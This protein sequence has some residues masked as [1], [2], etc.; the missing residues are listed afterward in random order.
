MPTNRR[1]SAGDPLTD[2]VFNTIII[3]TPLFPVLACIVSIIMP[4]MIRS[5][6]CRPTVPRSL[7]DN[8]ILLTNLCVVDMRCS[9]ILKL[10]YLIIHLPIKPVSGVEAHKR[11]ISLSCSVVILGKCHLDE[12][13][14]GS[15]SP[16][17]S[18]FNHTACPLASSS[19]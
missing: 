19:P 5:G 11:L 18:K 14:P 6:I 2:H 13:H 9:I 12:G 7:S 1:Y 16:S 10:L 8:K 3:K 17:R 15:R 4:K